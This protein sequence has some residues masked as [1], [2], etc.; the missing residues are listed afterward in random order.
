MSKIGKTRREFLVG[1]GKAALGAGAAAAVV[2]VGVGKIGTVEAAPIQNL[3]SNKKP[4]SLPV[5]AFRG[6]EPMTEISVRT[7]AGDK[8][9]FFA[10]KIGADG[11]ELA[12]QGAGNFSVG[13][14]PGRFGKKEWQMIDCKRGDYLVVDTRYKSDK[15]AHSGYGIDG[16]RG[17]MNAMLRDKRWHRD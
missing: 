5:L 13:V 3:I 17:P 8:V 4:D 16:D 12:L 15:T 2:Q 7:L 6:I 11:I 10:T 1:A 9:P 14:R